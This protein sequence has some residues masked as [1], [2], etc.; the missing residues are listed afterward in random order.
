MKY[1]ISLTA[2]YKHKIN[3]GTDLVFHHIKLLPHSYVL[4][5]FMLYMQYIT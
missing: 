2:A 3:I 1:S 4:M 5:Q